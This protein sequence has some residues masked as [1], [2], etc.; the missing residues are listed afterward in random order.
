MS[1]HQCQALMCLPWLLS[2]L[3]ETFCSPPPCSSR[4]GIGG[5]VSPLRKAREPS[6]QQGSLGRRAGTRPQGPQT[7]DCRGSRLS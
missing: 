1:Q 6:S 4:V 7:S 3:A 5:P 2:A